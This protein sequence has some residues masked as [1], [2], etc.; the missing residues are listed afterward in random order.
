MAS[1]VPYDRYA[2]GLRNWPFDAF[3]GFFDAPLATL[4]KDVSSFKMNV[5]DA[6][7]KYVV[8]AELPGVSRDQIDVELNE[9]RLSVSV[10]KKESDEEKDKNYLYKESGEWSATR[11]VY[12]KDAATA[13]LSAKLEGGVLTVNV[14]KQDQNANVTKVA[15]D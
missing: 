12:L 14:P 8:T 11:G 5:E 15:I 7:D 9:G 2:R 6:G 4:G 3:D 10:D 13:G 1:M